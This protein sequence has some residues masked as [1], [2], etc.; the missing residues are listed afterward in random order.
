MSDRH[1][2]RQALKRL[3]YAYNGKDADALAGL[4]TADVH[5]WSSL[6]AETSGRASVVA[7]AKELFAALP[8]ERM[9][10]DTVVTDGETIVVEFTSTG[11]DANDEPYEVEFTEVFELVDGRFAAIRTYI[12]PDVV[13]AISH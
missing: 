3:I 1:A 2:A 13:E 11:T 10:A 12:D 6:G 8:N 4:Y 7:H 9:E 5:L